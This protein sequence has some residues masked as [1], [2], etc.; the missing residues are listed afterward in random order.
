[1]NIALIAIAAFLAGGGIGFLVYKLIVGK[2]FDGAKSKAEK[3]ISDARS[4]SKEILVTAKDEALKAK[5]EIKKEFAPR[6]KELTELERSL[7]GREIGLDK[8]YD[9]LELERKN[10]LKKREEAEDL[11]QTLRDLRTKQEE[12]LERIAKMD[13]EQAKEVL[14][15]LAEKEG[16]EELVK[17]IKEV[18]TFVKEEAD[19]KARQIIAS[20]IQRLAP[21][22]TAETTISSVDIPSDEMKGRIIGREGR[23]IQAFEKVTGVDLVID[24]T[25]EVVVLS[26]FDPLRRA[27]AKVS[28]EKLVTDGRI[29]PTRIE[30][31][32]EKAKK[33]VAEDIKRSG[34]E[35]A[36]EV[37]VAGLV[38]EIIKVLGRLKY[39]TSYGQNQLMHSVEVAMLSG[40]LAEELGADVRVAKT[41]GLLHDLGKAVDQD[42]PGNHAVISAD[43]ARKYKIDANIV[44]A[45][46]AHHEDIEIKSVEAA[47][48]QAADAISSARPGARR[49]SLETYIKRLR[50]LETI[51]NTFPGVEKSFAIQAGREV[52]VIVIPA[53]IDDL[54]AEKMS[55][56]IAKKIEAE[57]QYPG[58]IKVNVIREIRAMEFAK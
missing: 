50:D 5:E 25:P 11:K 8:K 14:L 12:S 30:E 45:I 22:F 51:S 34:D 35:A 2:K 56:E 28:L 20:A 29:N 36:Y 27:L 55:K 24:D 48:V 31:V 23:N 17:K 4:E 3:I 42:V 6:E 54:G 49:E 40:L 39:R 47:I 21:E 9:Q 18:N 7:R 44:H 10:L 33:E 32:Y 19:T 13:K 26:S 37:G 43:I 38:P 57:M 52:R 58:Q 1:M 41:A 46:E 53:E 16:K 15:N